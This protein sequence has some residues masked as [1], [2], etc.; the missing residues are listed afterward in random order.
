MREG[1]AIS[2]A[3][4]FQRSCSRIGR[5]QSLTTEIEDEEEAWGVRADF[6]GSSSS[7]I[8]V[9]RYFTPLPL[10]AVESTDAESRPSVALR[11]YVNQDVRDTEP[12]TGHVHG[13][14]FIAGEHDFAAARHELDETSHLERAFTEHLSVS[15]TERTIVIICF[16]CRHY[17]R[18]AR[19]VSAR[20]FTNPYTARNADV[21]RLTSAVGV[22]HAS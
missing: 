9:D 8:L 15:E 20:D 4:R 16:V 3:Q 13:A 11:A 10:A 2:E 19:L 22:T 21:L 6:P 7:S 18:R 5:G 17:E 14:D 12:R 1:G